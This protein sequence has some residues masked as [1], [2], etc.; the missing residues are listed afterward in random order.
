[1]GNRI[2]PGLVERY[3][4][5]TNIDAQQTGEP[6]P[7]DHGDN[8]FEPAPGD[9]GAHGRFD[10]RARGSSAVSWIGRHRRAL[11]AAAGGLAA[12]AAAAAAALGDDD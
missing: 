5:R 6:V 4:A 7:P 2:A 3:L 8:L 11:M 10:D 9:S 1:V 12:A